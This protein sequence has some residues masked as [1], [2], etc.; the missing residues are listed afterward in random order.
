VRAGNNRGYI[1]KPGWDWATGLGS[2]DV[3]RAAAILAPSG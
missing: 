3:G 2:I 1:A